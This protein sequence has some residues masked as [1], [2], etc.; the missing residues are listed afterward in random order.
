[1]EDENQKHLRQIKSLNEK[2]RVYKRNEKHQYWG[3]YDIS[4]MHDE[5]KDE[6]FGS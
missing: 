6:E 2:L 4:K 3:N 1:M 5:Q